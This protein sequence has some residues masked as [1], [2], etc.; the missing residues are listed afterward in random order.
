[1]EQS[2]SQQK[3][4]RCVIKEGYLCKKGGRIPSWHKRWFNLKGDLLFYYRN[5]N[6]SKPLGSIPLAGNKLVRHPDDPKLP[7]QYRFEIITSTGQAISST[8][9]SFLMYA[10]SAEDARSWITAITKV[11]YEP[12]GGA[13]FG[14][15]LEETVTIEKKFGGGG[16]VPFIVYKCCEY[17]RKNG[18]TEVGIFRLPG[19][20]IRVNELKEMFNAGNQ[21]EFPTHLGEDVH[22]VA[23]LLKLYLRELPEPVVQHYN[24]RKVIDATKAYD[25]DSVN[26]ETVLRET[27]EQLPKPNYNLLK[28]ISRFLYDVQSH[29]SVNKMVS[30]NLGTVFGPNLLRPEGD[31]PQELVSCANLLTRF[32]VIIM[33]AHEGLFAHTD[34]EILPEKLNIPEKKSQVYNEVL[35]RKSSWTTS[36]YDESGLERK[37]TLQRVKKISSDRQ[38]TPDDSLI[39]FETEEYPED[40]SASYPE[41][42]VAR[43]L[44]SP[45]TE[46]MRQDISSLKTKISKERS[47][48]KLWK[49]RYETEKRARESAELRVKELQFVLNETFKRFALNY[50]DEADEEDQFS[51]EVSEL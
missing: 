27:L 24:Y 3:L 43:K 25:V 35:S 46:A 11:M 30:S 42:A 10:E 45:D 50:E 17:V 16:Y 22:T 19:S 40:T 18:L 34:D 36:V 20:T 33:E 1:M 41:L 44:H 49:K 13:M 15:S 48:G 28:Y 5:V 26:G 32:V 31:D 8:H 39:S 29:S 47:V 9:D 37:A 14:R 4:N 21:V 38:L 51:D 6:D 7:N 2:F 12:Y 23:S